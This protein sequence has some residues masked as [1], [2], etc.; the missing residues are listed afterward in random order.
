M[1]DQLEG[2]LVDLFDNK[3]AKRLRKSLRRIAKQLGEQVYP[4]GESPAFVDDE[5]EDEE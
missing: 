3:D 5:A 1:T 4:D 2:E